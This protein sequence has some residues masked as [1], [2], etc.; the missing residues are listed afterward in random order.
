[1]LQEG[2]EFGSPDFVCVLIEVVGNVVGQ[3]CQYVVPVVTV[4]CCVIVLD[5]ADGVLPMGFVYV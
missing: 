5:Q 4:E 2:G 3:K 1:M